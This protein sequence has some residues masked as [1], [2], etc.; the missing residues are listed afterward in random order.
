MRIDKKKKLIDIGL[1]LWSSKDNVILFWT[2]FFSLRL[3]SGYWIIEGANSS[4]I[5][6]EQMYQPH[7]FPARGN[8]L[9]LDR[10]VFTLLIVYIPDKLILN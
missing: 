6:L 4:S 3:N 10:M 5:N 9:Y 2:V 1:C 7:S 8:M